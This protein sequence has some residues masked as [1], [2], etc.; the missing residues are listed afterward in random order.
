MRTLALTWDTF[1]GSLSF[2]RAAF[3]Y[4]KRAEDLTVSLTVLANGTA[5][6]LGTNALA[7][8]KPVNNYSTV[9]AHW[10]S[11]SRVGSTNVYTST[12]NLNTNEIVALLGNTTEIANCVFDLADDEH[13]E[14]D[15]L[16]VVLKN[17]VTRDT[18]GS[19]TEATTPDDQWVAHGHVQTA[20]RADSAAQAV[21]RENIGAAAVGSGVTT[22]AA[23]TDAATADLPGINT[24]LAAALAGKLDTT[25]TAADVNP[26]GTAI[27]AAL[28]A[29][30]A[31]AVAA[32][33][34]VT[35]AVQY[36]DAGGNTAGDDFITADGAG[37]LLLGV[38]VNSA[39]YSYVGATGS[40]AF[41][42][43]SS[44][45]ADPSTFQGAV[46]PGGGFVAPWL[47]FDSAGVATFHGDGSGLENLSPQLTSDQ[48]AGIN[49]AT[50][51]LTAINRVI[52]A[53]DLSGVA[54][55][56]A[57]SDLSG[58]PAVLAPDGDGALLYN[59]LHGS[60]AG[61]VFLAPDGDGGGL[62]FTDSAS[63]LKYRLALT[64]GVVG[65]ELVT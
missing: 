24:A 46:N 40:T 56:G 47:T 2:D 9:L 5:S 23:L 39:S 59:V 22:F 10:N 62:T 50:N 11:F 37:A 63:G 15:T 44:N 42:F 32:Q 52:T 60:D 43:A 33:G 49:A 53:A 48:L 14:S 26:A 7:T 31:A 27:A 64:G 8:L 41:G 16:A 30:Q 25:A 13:D 51:P 57:Y 65:W 61:T 17:N 54:T 12:V 45:S 3:N 38:G 58:T 29:V 1:T 20:L 28:A 34:T 36:R 21:A 18:D 19:P 4:A 6:T 35:G 55:S